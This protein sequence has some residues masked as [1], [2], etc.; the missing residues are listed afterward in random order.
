MAEVVWSGA[1]SE[2]LDQIIAYLEQ[3]DSVAAE[4]IGDKLIAPAQ[5]LDIFPNRG[6]PAPRGTRELVTVPPYVLRYSVRGDL[7][8]IRSVRHGRR[9]PLR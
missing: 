6:R 9:R 1:A 7:V 4:A 2:E 5:S 8:I 3:F